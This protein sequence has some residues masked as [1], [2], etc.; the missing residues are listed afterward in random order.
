MPVSTELICTGKQQP[1]LPH[2]IGRM[3]TAC[4]VAY[5]TAMPR[6]FRHLLMLAMCIVACP[7]L[8]TFQIIEPW[9]RPASTAL[10]GEAFMQLASTDGASLVGVRCDRAKSVSLVQGRSV[11]QPLPLALP[12]G[13]TVQLAPG[14][15]RIVL[16]QLDRPL[17][18]GERVPMVL[19][20]RD[21]SG[22]LQE[23]AVD[24]E[25]RRRSPT[26]DHRHH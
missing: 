26:A 14:A 22:V 6:P 23:I 19:V 18:I 3:T 4:N 7:A 21:S 12:S 2:S 10:R 20:I 24:A 11:P 5:D 1:G 15:T 8:A 9:V 16:G 25:V 17:R 13:K